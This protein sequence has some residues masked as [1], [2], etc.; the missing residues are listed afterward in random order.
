MS[1]VEFFANHTFRMV[2]FGTSLI[3]LVAGTLG[4]FAYLRKQAMVSDVVSHAALPGLLGAFWVS[5]ALFGDGRNMAALMIG[6]IVAGIAAV[7]LADRITHWSKVG[8]DAAMAIVLSTFFGIGLIIMHLGSRSGQK[9]QG[10]VQDYLFGNASTLTHADITTTVVVGALGGII[11]IV[12][13]RPLG[14][15]CFDPHFSAVRGMPVRL[16][17]L[18]IFA[19]IV[20][21]TVVGLKAVGLVLMVAFVLMPPAAARQWV[22]SIRGL[23][24]LSGLIGAGASGIGAYLSISIGRIPTGPLVVLMLF[25]AVVVSLVAAPHRS[26]LM[27]AVHRARLRRRLR[28]S[29]QEGI[30]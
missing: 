2:F 10:G 24:L 13:G 25:A 23:F 1:P 15:R 5:V 22:G 27:R 26:V 8:L 29:L 20:V 19:L 16:L 9:G 14:I 7:W 17:D 18:T 6:S 3:G 12:L 30:S 11:L 21:A 28:L 4:C